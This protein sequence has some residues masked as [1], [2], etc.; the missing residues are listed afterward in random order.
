M[1][2]GKLST[3]ALQTLIDGD[4]EKRNTVFSGTPYMEFVKEC[5]FA[6]EKNLPLSSAEKLLASFEFEA[7]QARKYELK[8][9]EPFFY[10]VLGRRIENSNI[11]I[12]FAGKF[13]G[14]SEAEIKRRLRAY[15]GGVR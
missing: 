1:P 6:K 14:L 9:E 4:A 15:N 5:I 13:T 12:L 3:Q 10:Y 8:K 11:R 7:F 2:S